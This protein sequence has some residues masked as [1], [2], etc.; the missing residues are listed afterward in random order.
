VFAPHV[1]TSTGM[2]LPDDYI[3]KVGAACKE[4][5]AL[6]VLDC[7]ASGTVWVDMKK[8]G[9]DVVISAPQKGWSG[10]AAVGLAM[11]SEKATQRMMDGPESSSFVVNLR[12]WQGIMDLYEKGAFG[13]HT[14]L[15]TD[16]IRA[17]R[18]IADQQKE[19]GLGN[20]K[21]SQISM[22]AMARGMLESKGL[23]SVAAPGFQAPGVLVYYSPDGMANADMVSKFRSVGLQIAA[24]V[25]WEINEPAGLKTFRIGLF[26][27]D[28]LMNAQKTVRTLEHGL[29]DVMGNGV[30]SSWL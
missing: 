8:L 19:L 6:F 9:I 3:A 23:R 18:E 29:D 22:G 11:L 1:E 15:P 10:P 14:T 2:M 12:K 20:L 27:I 21:D 5:G 16:A 28:K 25:P 7:I 4:T 24:G 30:E 13:Y 26:G 17:F